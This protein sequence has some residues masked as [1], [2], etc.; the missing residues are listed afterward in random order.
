[1]QI[2]CNTAGI[3]ADD[4]I[5]TADRTAMTKIVAAMSFVENGT[6]ADACDVQRGFDLFENYLKGQ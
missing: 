6:E 3:Y 5:N 1:V 4:K 2:V